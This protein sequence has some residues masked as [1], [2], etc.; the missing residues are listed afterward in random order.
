MKITAD[1]LTRQLASELGAAAVSAEPG[2]LAAHTVDGKVPALICAPATPEQLALALGICSEAQAAVIPWGGG[3]AMAI[4][5]PPRRADVILKTHQFNRIIDHDHANLTVTVQ[6]GIALTTLQAALA[7]QKQFA[8]FDAP[9]PERSTLGGIVAANLNGP[10]RS[11]WGSVRYL[12]IGM[13]VVLASGEQIKAGGKVVKNVAGYDMCKLF[14]GS[15]GTLGIVTELTV[16]VAPVP[17]CSA[18]GMAWGTLEQAEKLAGEITTSKLL[19]AADFLRNNAVEQNWR[20]AASFEGFAETVARQLRELDSMA[21]RLGMRIESLDAQAEQQ[22]WQELR[23]LP[24][25]AGRLVFRM[26]VPRKSLAHMIRALETLHSGAPAPTIVADMAMGTIW[27]VGAANQIFAGG[28]SQLISLAQQQRGHAVMFA[29]PAQLKQGVEVWGPAPPA[30]ALMREIKQK[31]DPQG[32]LN[33]GRFVG[34][35]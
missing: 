21:R 22:F 31:F 7:P 24:L 11:S 13:K 26:T 1:Q 32:I 35:F 15:L 2:A 27:S 17:E 10:R 29:A 4:G 34:G 28:F 23:D 12:V 25:A 3:T 33:P 9:F 20:L 8:P 6:S 30:L 14:T 18:S 19:P 5:N 16:R